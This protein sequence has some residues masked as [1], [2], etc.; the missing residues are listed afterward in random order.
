MG[1]RAEVIAIDVGGTHIKAGRF[2]VDGTC[3]AWQKLETA[4]PAAPEVVIEQMA[5]I[6]AVLDP[7]RRAVAVGIGV[8]GPTDVAGRKALVAI[9]LHGWTDVPLADRLESLVDRPV[10]LANDANCA[11]LGEAWLGAGRNSRLFMLLT[12]GTGVGGAVVVDGQLFTGPHGAGGE[13]GLIAVHPD[14]PECNSGN[15]GSLEQYVSATAIRRRTGMGG[16]ELDRKARAGDEQ[17]IA[18]W[19]EIGK[20]LGIGLSSLIYVLTPEV[21][22]IG[23]G[24][25]KCADL[26][27]PAAIAEIERRVLPSSR[28]NLKVVPAQLGNRAGCVG[29]AR[30]A[31]DLWNPQSAG[32]AGAKI[33]SGI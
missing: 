28:V 1:D 20:D 33:F 29:A 5:E 30:L 3:L 17:A 12:L 15:R 6:V 16:H 24:I 25:S 26:F 14:G 32:L 8:P 11:G 23:G 13:L 31:F 18:H 10:K 9:N 22:A 4:Q 19:T 2:N 27:L 7:D 21:I